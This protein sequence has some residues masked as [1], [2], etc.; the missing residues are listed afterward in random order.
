MDENLMPVHKPQTLGDAMNQL[1]IDSAASMVLGNDKIVLAVVLR[2]LEQNPIVRCMIAEELGEQAYRERDAD[3]AAQSLLEQSDFLSNQP[4][5][6]SWDQIML[7]VIERLKDTPGGR[8][9]V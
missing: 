6:K 5:E 3:Q 4:E 2:I 8:G 1:L 7:E 9:E